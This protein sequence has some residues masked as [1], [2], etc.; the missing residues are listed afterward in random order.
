MAATDK[1]H[2]DQRT[3]DIVFAL[4]CLA[5]LGSLVWMFVQDY[6][7]E[8]KTEQRVFYD[9][10]AEMAMRQALDQMPPVAEVDEAEKL[11]AD[12]RKSRDEKKISEAKNQ[13]RTIEPKKEKAD[14]EFQNVKA[15]L[16]SRMSFYNSAKENKNAKLVA[17]YEDEL[18]RLNRD[19]AQAQAEK[20]KHTTELRA[21]QNEL[22]ELEKPLNDALLKE[23]TLNDKFDAQVRLALKSQYG[24]AQRVRAFPI[25]EAFA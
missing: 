18:S 15:N 5:M 1:T 16:E 21:K 19:L 13:I 8:W 24:L 6:N 9:V 3:L 23:R 7:G 22:I 17:Y 2:R 25:L 12:A 20:D 10:K 14:A 4:S 11:V